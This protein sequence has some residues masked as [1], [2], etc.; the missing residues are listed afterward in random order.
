MDNDSISEAVVARKDLRMSDNMNDSLAE[1]SF[2]PMKIPECKRLIEVVDS[3][4]QEHVH[5]DLR[6]QNQWAHILEHGESTMI[7]NHG[8]MHTGPVG[9]S[10]VYYPEVPENSGNIVWTFEANAHRVIE[11]AVPEVGKLILFG[12]DVPHFT[13]KNNSGKRRISISGNAWFDKVPQNY[14][15]GALLNYTGLFR[16]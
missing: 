4:I 14:Q 1:D 13:K 7:H 16:G 2:F 8:G 6:T 12:Q 9:I 10:W 15:P 5:S 11:E 3:I